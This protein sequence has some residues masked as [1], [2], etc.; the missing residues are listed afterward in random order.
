ME[1]KKI[2]LI[3]TTGLLLAASAISQVNAAAE[4]PAA[5]ATINLYFDGWATGDTTKVGKAMHTTCHLKFY[6]E[7][8]FT[9]MD[10]ATY[11]GRFKQPPHERDKNLITRIVLLDI[12]ENIASAKAEIITAKDIFTDYFNLIKTGEGWFIVDKVSVKT[13]K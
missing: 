1:M 7:G 11:L 13:P 2:I 4:K 3:L 6:R 5:E 8:K 9:D 10:R 12:T